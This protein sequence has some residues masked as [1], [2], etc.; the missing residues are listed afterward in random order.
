MELPPALDEEEAFADESAVRRRIALPDG[1]SLRT[2]TA[3]GVLINSCFEIGLTVLGFVRRVGIAAFLTQSQYGLWGLIL[4]TLITLSWL[5]QI[6][7]SDK[8][9]QQ[10]DPNEEHA[11]QKAFTLE[12]LYSV[13]MYVV[14]VAALPL[15]AVIYGHKEIILPG[16]IVALALIVAAFQTPI[17]SA[18][19]HMEFVRQRSLE[20]IDPVVALAVTFGLGAA[21]YGYWSLVWGGLVGATASAIAAVATSRYKLA[22]RYDRGTMREYFSFSWPLFISALSGLAVVQGTVIVGNISVGLAGVGLIGLAGSFTLFADRV[23]QIVRQTIYPAVCAVRERRDLF[24]EAFLKSN[25]IGVLF[26]LTFGV[27]VFFF[28]PDL[29]TYVLGE[30]WRGAAG[31]LQA[32]GLI[33]GFRQ[34]AYNWTIFI[35]ADGETRPLAINSA[36]QVAAFFLI[37]AP[38]ILWLGVT[39]YAIG[40]AAAVAVDVASRMY[41]LSKLFPGFRILSYMYR[42]LLP[43]IPA[44][45]AVGAIRLLETGPRTLGMVVIEILVYLAVTAAATFKFERPLLTEIAGYLRGAGRVR[46]AT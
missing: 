25:R 18:Y 7:I 32:L 33:V 42:S 36:L 12:L 28:G 29:I 20:S 14:I 10:D 6:G 35:R 1:R 40:T 23:D 46:E 44:V 26:G 21:G 4:T 45:L 3:R 5:K 24:F 11:F 19:R 15:Y 9:V 30:K 22:F 39:G 43:T 8:Y 16:A 31:L 37:T 41:F 13:L 2:H 17:W 27:G 38:L 34:I